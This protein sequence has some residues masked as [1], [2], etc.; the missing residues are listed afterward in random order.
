M[1][2][3]NPFYQEMCL[4]TQHVMQVIQEVL[5]A[6]NWNVTTEHAVSC[7]SH[8]VVQNTVVLYS[9]LSAVMTGKPVVHFRKAVHRQHSESAPILNMAYFYCLACDK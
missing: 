6:W 5:S 2:F 8:C 1:Q 9:P 3:F 7:W 4:A